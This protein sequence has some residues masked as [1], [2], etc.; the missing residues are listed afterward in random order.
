MGF[1]FLTFFEKGSSVVSLESLERMPSSP[2][3]LV[4]GELV[5]SI[6]SDRESVSLDPISPRR[7]CPGQFTRVPV[8]P[9]LTSSALDPSAHFTQPHSPGSQ[10]ARVTFRE[11]HFPQPTPFRPSPI[12]PSSFSPDQ[13]AWPK[14]KQFAFERLQPL[15]LHRYTCFCRLTPMLI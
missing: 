13:F 5:R 4:R 1:R 14:R 3:L 7:V 11:A 2:P 10:F 12:S 8:R 6:D 9:S 15:I